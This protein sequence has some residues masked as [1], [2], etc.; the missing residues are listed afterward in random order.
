MMS[1]SGRETPYILLLTTPSTDSVACWRNAVN[2]L[3]TVVIGDRVVI[4]LSLHI[5]SGLLRIHCI[6]LLHHFHRQIGNIHV[7]HVLLLKRAIDITC[8]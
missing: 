2:I 1:S 3:T 4:L 8:S 5:S 7:T 6:S